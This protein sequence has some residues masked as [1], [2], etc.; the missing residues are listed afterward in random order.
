MEGAKGFQGLNVDIG[1]KASIQF[2]VQGLGVG[3]KAPSIQN[4]DSRPYDCE[5]RIFL[6]I[7]IPHV[8]PKL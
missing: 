6:K 3:W 7:A 4:F 8:R 5:S 1:M 2:R